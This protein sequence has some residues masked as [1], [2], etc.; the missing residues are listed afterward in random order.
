M[1][2]SR[3]ELGSLVLDFASNRLDATFV[4]TNGVPSDWFT[5]IKEPNHPPVANPAAYSRNA[6]FSL[7]IPIAELA[8]NWF[9]V[10]GDALEL[11]GIN[12][13][14]NGVTPTFDS[15]HIYYHNANDVADQF[16]YVISDGRGGDTNGIINVIMTPAGGGPTMNILGLKANPDGSMTVR[17][18]GVPGYVYGVQGTTN[19]PPSLLPPVFWLTLGT[20]TAGSNGLWE[21]VD[22]NAASYPQGRYYRSFKP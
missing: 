5:I 6:G 16:S 12:P 1:Y 11:T 2:S 8:T 20:H 9:D 10:D 14:T 17:F 13:S 21:F 18:A 7:K 15:S 19:Q 22:T 3:N 4:P